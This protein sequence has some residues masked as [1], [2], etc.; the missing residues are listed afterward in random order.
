MTATNT[1]PAAQT[2]EFDHVMVERIANRIAFH[3][4]QTEGTLVAKLG[5]GAVDAIQVALDLG[6]IKEVPRLGGYV[7]AKK[8]N[9]KVFGK[10]FADFME[11]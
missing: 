8:T 4:H 2:A 7:A 3:G 11:G 1:T 10:G 6:L 5:E 9:A